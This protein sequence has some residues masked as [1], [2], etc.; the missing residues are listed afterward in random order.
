MAEAVT[1]QMYW[2]DRY[3]ES[4]RIWSGQPNAALVREAAGLPPGRALDLGCG[5]G[6]DAVWLARQGWQVTAVDISDVALGR[7][8]GHARDEG[9][10]DRI[11]FQRHTLG[12]TFP[13]GAFDLI[14]AC[15][16]HSFTDLPREEILRIAAGAV[17]P[18]G[19][20]LVVSHAGVPHIQA[21]HPEVVFPTPEEVLAALELREGGWD[22]LRC[23]EH[24]TEQHRE[25]EP[26]RR[27]DNTVKV[28]RRAD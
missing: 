26:D 5:E 23:A 16:L 20:L 11:D 7:A 2:D 17:A 6:G 19:T 21:E 27:T 24:E 10:A 28:R 9:V 25:G 3:R 4:G 13:A 18:G 22:V 15:Y 1:D 8:A 12:E 14:S